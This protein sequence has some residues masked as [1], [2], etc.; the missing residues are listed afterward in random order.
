MNNPFRALGYRLRAFGARMEK[1]FG[2]IDLDE[3]RRIVDRY[4]ASRKTS[5]KTKRAAWEHVGNLTPREAAGHWRY[6][7]DPLKRRGRPVGSDIVDDQLLAE[8]SARMEATGKSA[9]TV[10]RE[11]IAERGDTLHADIDHRADYV[12]RLYKQR[13]GK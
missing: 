1:A 3:V 9:R 2:D 13:T 7:P 12:A 10:A 6:L 11:I 8:I 4:R 5:D